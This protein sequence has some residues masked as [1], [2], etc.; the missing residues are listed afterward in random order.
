MI[1]VF[2]VDVY[3][4]K[5]QNGY[6]LLNLA[7]LAIRSF[8]HQVNNGKY[9]GV[10]Y[11]LATSDDPCYCIK[12]DYH[13]PIYT[14]LEQLELLLPTEPS[15]I[16][17]GF[18]AVFELL[19]FRRMIRYMDSFYRGRYVEHNE[20]TGIFWF[21]DGKNLNF[22]KSC[23]DYQSDHGSSPTSLFYQGKNRW[24]QKLYTIF[25]SSETYD[26]PPE[27][28]SLNSS[29]RGQL[30]FL[31]TAD[32]VI[33]VIGNILGTDKE[34]YENAADSYPYNIFSTCG[35]LLNFVETKCNFDSTDL[36][37]IY[38]DPQKF[39]GF[40][41][42]PEEFWIEPDVVKFPVDVAS[43]NRRKPIPTI[44][45]WKKND[46]KFHEI[47]PNFPRD[48]YVVSECGMAR[49]LK[50]QKPGTKW[51]I[52]ICNSSKS[53]GYGEPFGYLTVNKKNES[54]M[55]VSL[56]I[57]P[58]NYPL[59][60]KL[61]YQLKQYSDPPSSWKESMENYRK[62]LPWYY[63]QPLSKSFIICRLEKFI[64]GSFFSKPKTDGLDTLLCQIVHQAHLKYEQMKNYIV[65]NRYTITRPTPYP[66][67][68][69]KGITQAEKTLTKIHKI[70]MLAQ[71]GNELDSTHSVNT[72]I[73]GNYEEVM[74]KRERQ[75]LRD[76]FEDNIGKKK[77][78]DQRAFG[79]PFKN[80]GQKPLAKRTFP[81]LAQKFREKLEKPPEPINFP[82]FLN[83]GIKPFVIIP[84]RQIITSIEAPPKIRSLNL[85][86]NPYTT[87]VKPPQS[88]INQA[89]RLPN[90]IT[91]DN[92]QV[93]TSLST[94]AFSEM[95]VDKN[96]GSLSNS[97][98]LVSAS[99][100]STLT[101]NK[102]QSKKLLLSNLDDKTE[103]VDVNVEKV[104]NVKKSHSSKDKDK[105]IEYNKLNF[106][107]QAAELV[108]A[109]EPP[110]GLDMLS[111]AA[112]QVI[113]KPS[114][115]QPSDFRLKP[116]KNIRNYSMDKDLSKLQLSKFSEDLRMKISNDSLE[117][118][119]NTIFE[120]IEEFINSRNYS[121]EIK[122]KFLYSI[123]KFA[124][125]NLKLDL[126]RKIESLLQDRFNF[127]RNLNENKLR[128]M[129]EFYS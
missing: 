18:S 101:T 55:E 128:P 28:R 85:P 126:S 53:S 77:K 2:L 14:F 73:M 54:E 94:P 60:F 61:L 88:Q 43:L 95:N 9:N 27:L 66:E 58:Y 92:P 56:V 91:L 81:K 59:L 31:Q 45:Y 5:T 100:N 64:P 70:T 119:E 71:S 48:T 3:D 19:S 49:E 7:K 8:V 16:G 103:K 47:P 21:T 13:D 32:D 123:S 34:L 122:S 112:S 62:S 38:V 78:R 115:Q 99:L 114:D 24:D 17:S 87:I 39:E 41:P 129:N 125:A 79:S 29:M 109:E 124:Q 118:D 51:P 68:D 84:G 82:G 65:S 106:L 36:G 67:K 23:L 108:L 63:L 57:L 121:N 104:E 76:P 116:I 22:L 6:N 89:T 111:Q 12:T 72:L 35:V 52:Y 50:C 69:I 1:I 15:K 113:D 127:K 102:S 20:T 117:Y 10:K 97:D 80:P 90:N 110:T 93:I 25:L 30:Y 44:S 42:I 40:Y 105:D 120:Q 98:M 11:V 96:S 107:S 26:A 75:E 4:S 83:K 46:F 33:K 74:A 37:Q 86:A